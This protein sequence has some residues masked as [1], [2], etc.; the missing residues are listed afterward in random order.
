M[1]E[2]EYA[3]DVLRVI[4]MIMVIIIH[5]SN[6]YTRSFNFI[7]TNSYLVSL[8]FNTISR[9]SVPNS[10]MGYIIFNLGIFI[11]WSNIW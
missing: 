7:D 4:A 5:V 10:S 6:V 11:S 3:F 1:K 8:I 9:V 2:R